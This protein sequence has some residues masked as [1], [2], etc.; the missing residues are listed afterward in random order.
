MSS[1]NSLTFPYD[2]DV[3]AFEHILDE[4]RSVWPN[5]HAAFSLFFFA[6]PRLPYSLPG[7]N[8]VSYYRLQIP[9][10]LAECEAIAR[11]SHRIRE[12]EISDQIEGLKLAPLVSRWGA[13]PMAKSATFSPENTPSNPCNTVIESLHLTVS[14]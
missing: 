10:S 13:W 7:Y 5:V 11:Y 9:L 1:S 6:R 12:L 14:A 4:G 2:L 8:L 3:F